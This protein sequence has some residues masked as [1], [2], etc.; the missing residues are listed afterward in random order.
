MLEQLARVLE[1]VRQ[2]DHARV[3][4]IGVRHHDLEATGIDFDEDLVEVAGADL[5]PKGLR[6]AR[7]ACLVAKHKANVRDV[8]ALSGPIRAHGVLPRGVEAFERDAQFLEQLG[9]GVR[10]VAHLLVE[11][12]LTERFGL[13]SRHRD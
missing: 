3:L 12:R 13:H 4:A 7:V 10:A 8:G 1:G 5:E 9:Q 11:F 2:R 6:R